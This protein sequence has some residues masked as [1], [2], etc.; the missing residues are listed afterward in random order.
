MKLTH[1]L[2]IVIYLKKTK[3]SEE[4]TTYGSNKTMH[5]TIISTVA[6]EPIVIYS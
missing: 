4:H 1:E 3:I 6:N 2:V 5:S